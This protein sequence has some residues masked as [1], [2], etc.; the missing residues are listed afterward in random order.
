M[1]IFVKYRY[2]FFVKFR[3]TIF[4]KQKFSMTFKFSYSYHFTAMYQSTV[5]DTIDFPVSEVPGRLYSMPTQQP[6]APHSQQQPTFSSEFQ[7]RA[8]T[9]QPQPTCFKVPP[10]YAFM[11]QP[12]TSQMP[13]R[14]LSSPLYQ[15]QPEIVY[16]LPAQPQPVVQYQPQPPF[17]QQQPQPAQQTC[18]NPFMTRKQ[19][20]ENKQKPQFL[21]RGARRYIFDAFSKD[22]LM[23]MHIGNRSVFGSTKEQLVKSAVE[24]TSTR[25]DVINL[26]LSSF[27]VSSED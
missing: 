23:A 2:I 19:R 14:T 18:Q 17:V 26:I 22:Q 4:D 20:E 27:D 7:R 13:Q 11:Y 9:P 25:D 15:A 5:D 24:I 1:L 6:T 10:G 3:L 8:P 12:A 16:S 21:T